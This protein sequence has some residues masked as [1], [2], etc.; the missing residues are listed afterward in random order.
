MYAETIGYTPGQ[1]YD[2]THTQSQSVRVLSEAALENRIWL[3]GGASAPWSDL[4]SRLSDESGS[5][6]ERDVTDGKIYN[7]CIVFSPEGMPWL[8]ISL[9]VAHTFARKTRSDA[10][11]SSPV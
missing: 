4:T 11:Q 7:T 5:I 10:S 6:P 8:Y 1:E 9:F 3:I 2:T